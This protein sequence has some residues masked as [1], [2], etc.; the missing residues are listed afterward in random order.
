MDR[1]LIVDDETP[2]AE[3]LCQLFEIE[4][5]A[6]AAAGDRAGAERMLLAEHYPVILADVRLRSE[7]EGLQ[8]LESI[9]RL[10]PRSR[11]ATMTGYATPALEQRLRSLGARQILY[12]PFEFDELLRVVRELLGEDEPAGTE[13]D[14]EAL[15]EQ[16]R[17][18]LF[19]L[20]LRRF[21]LG[22]E[23]A[24]DVVQ[25]AWCLFL[26]KQGGIRQP[27][28]WLSGT[29]ANLCRQRLEERNRMVPTDDALFETLADSRARSADTTLAVR[30]ALAAT[31][32]RSRQLCFLIGLENRS[33]EEVS[34]RLGI[35]VGSVGPLYI[36]AKA[37]M[38][39]L[40]AP[41]G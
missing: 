8:L 21:G 33:Y 4:N 12:K 28:A 11:I 20:P 24:E 32:E 38:R 41:R 17:A 10:S 35:P 22:S 5:I 25:Q 15:H 39:K 18:L 37:R 16:M 23:D 13:P 40:L 6:A 30:A 3:A 2:L 14:L 29:V 34:A 1:I 27:R 36:R 9:R 31:D 26:E 19:S 7:E